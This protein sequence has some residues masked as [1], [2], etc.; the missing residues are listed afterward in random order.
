MN[1]IHKTIAMLASFLAIGAVHIPTYADTFPSKPVTLVVPYPPGGP[2]DAIAR[3]VAIK[4]GERW[5]QSV[6]VDNRPGGSEVIASQ[7]VIN[8]RP[9]GYTILVAGDPAVAVN[10]FTFKN[11]P[12]DPERDFA[13]V[14]RMVNFNMAFVVPSSNPVSSMIEFLTYS[15]GRPGALAF[16]SAGQG[17][18]VHFAY[19]DL[20]TAAGVDLN[21]IPYPG[22]API[23]TDMLGGRIDATFGAVAT[24]QP[25]VSSGKL[26]ALAIGGQ[27]RSK[28]LPDVPTLE[29]LGL[30]D[31]IA[32]FYIGLVVPSKTPADVVSFIAREV[33][34]VMTTPEFIAKTIDPFAVELVA[35]DPASFKTF[36]VANRKLQA[37]RVKASGFQ[38]N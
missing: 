26:K 35:D 28:I 7:L 33:R 1:R 27:R 30:K 18:P 14:I 6:N 38:A 17:G 37:A 11:L 13:P 34:E 8:S 16:G 31:V 19:T 25:Y 20:K 12:Y 24:V 3:A 9:D 29:E 10:Q 32:S 36:L 15:K 2:I 22:L 4:L 5:K 23:I 21:F